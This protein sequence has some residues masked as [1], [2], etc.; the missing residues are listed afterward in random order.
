MS[1][2]LI[3][4]YF[5]YKTM[6]FPKGL[7]GTNIGL[8][9]D[10][11]TTGLTAKDDMFEIALIPFKFT[12]D[13]VVT[14][15]GKPYIAFEEHELNDFTKKLCNIPDDS[16]LKGKSFDD[17]K[18]LELFEQADII[19]AHHAAF[20]RPFFDRRFPYLPKKVWGCSMTDIDWRHRHMIGSVALDYIAFKKMF[21]FDKHRA[22]NDCFA[23]VKILSDAPEGNKGTHLKELVEKAFTPSFKIEVVNFPFDDKDK[24]KERG[25][26]WNGDRKCWWKSVD[27]ETRV[28]ESR[29]LDENSDNR[30]EVDLIEVSNVNRF[31]KS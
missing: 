1:K 10:C 7:V 24:L 15:F 14:G 11:E 22:A 4:K 31:A 18:V 19:I 23:T 30:T 3:I 2:D 6:E 20:D 29:F 13:Y 5:D 8:M 9:V 16:V 25:Y 21:W 28:A 27:D 17:G 12:D 26:R